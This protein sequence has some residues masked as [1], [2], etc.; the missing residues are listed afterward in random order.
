MSLRN[1]LIRISLL[2]STF[3]FF[4]QPAFS[5]ERYNYL[6]DLTHVK[7]DKLEVRLNVPTIK[8]KE[9]IFS[10]PKIIPG[11]YRISDYGKFAG[12]IIAK[13]K[14]GKILKVTKVET[15]SWK[16]SGADKL[17]TIVY[18]VEDTYDTQIPNAVFPMAGTN[19]DEGKNFV[20]NPFGFFGYFQGMKN[21]PV[22]LT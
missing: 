4:M 18:R 14:S 21:L 3:A 20:L 10:I 11:T 15:N 7:D 17:A 22:D 2:F 1:R 8:Q 5:Q 16:I 6:V 19:I 13:D 12:E 9:I